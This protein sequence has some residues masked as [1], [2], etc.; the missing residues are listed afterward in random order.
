MT[1]KVVIIGGSYAGLAA[2]N[3]LKLLIT[4]NSGAIAKSIS[5]TLIEPKS[6][7]LNILGLPKSIVNKEFAS[8][9]Y[10]PFC[11]FLKFDNV[12]SNSNDLKV[13]LKENTNSDN[14]NLMLN[15]IQGKVTKLTSSR[16]TYTTNDTDESSIDYDYAILATGRNRNWPVNPKGITFESYL[17][18]MEITNK[19]IQKSSIISI[20]G[21]GAVGIE[22]AAEIK[23][24]YPNKVVNLIHP[25]GTLPPEPILDAFKNKT[26]Q[27]LKQANINVFLNTR[28]DT[29]KTSL[30]NGET[31]NLKTTDGKTI[32]SNLN[33]WA[34][35][36]KNNLDYL[37]LDLQR[38]IHITANHNIKTNDYLQ[39]SN[40]SNIY[41]VG[42]LIEL[43]TI[44]SAGWAF[45]TGIQAGTNVYNFI[46][47]KPLQLSR[48]SFNQI[49]SHKLTIVGGEG[50]II[51]E[52][53]G[54]LEINPESMVQEYQDY[55]LGTCKKFIGAT[56]N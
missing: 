35:S 39:V 3:T 15:Y 49:D 11:N 48:I 8:Q 40:M 34:T 10:V 43:S 38:S 47:D 2:L 54:N 23:L 6:G 7:F 16:V 4:K 14:N 21:G 26:L 42:D 56:V 9:Q 50:S 32:E 20:I 18:E 45:H 22:L 53:K 41:A 29:S 37:S 36:F 27:S 17:N 30:N 1:S 46:F 52:V 55:R 33:I 5:I 13:Q 28:I 51:H 24:H 25:H 19:K 31:S 12:V 44:K